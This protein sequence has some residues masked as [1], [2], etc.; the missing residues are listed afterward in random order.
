MTEECSIEF[1]F[2]ATPSKETT[3]NA[4]PVPITH[5]IQHRTD[6]ERYHHMKTFYKAYYTHDSLDFQDFHTYEKMPFIG[7]KF[8]WYYKK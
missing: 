5:H 6:D 8:V 4:F 1:Y 7:E 3:P 2:H